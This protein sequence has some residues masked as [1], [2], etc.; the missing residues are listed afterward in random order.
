META[1]KIVT[2]RSRRRPLTLPSPRKGGGD[3]SNPVSPPPGGE[4]GVRGGV[5]PE[6]PRS[7]LESRGLAEPRLPSPAVGRDAISPH[8]A[9]EPEVD[10]NILRHEPFISEYHDQ[11]Y[12]YALPRG[13]RSIYACYEVDSAARAHLEKTQ[14]PGFF[15][16]HYLVLRAR[17]VDNNQSW[18][19]EDYLDDKTSYWLTV[20]PNAEY[21]LELGY[22]RKGTRS[23]H[24]VALSNRVRSQPETDTQAECQNERRSIQVQ[25]Y[26]REVPVSA[27]EWRWNMYQYW[28]N[29]RLDRPAEQGCWALVLHMHLPF[30][31]HIEE[32]VALEEQWLFEAM[33]SCY[34]QLL[35]VFWNLD[36]AKIDFRMT[37]SI[38]PP[39]ISMLTD[40]GLQARYRA[41]LKEALALAERELRQHRGQA[42]QATLESILGRLN[43]A[44]KVFESYGGNI[45]NGFR[46]FQNLEKLEIITCA[47]THPILP[48]YMHYPEIVRGHIQLA[49][50]QYQRVFGRWPRGMWLPEN[51]FVPGLDH[52]L[53]AEGIKWTLVN[54]TGLAR[55][56]TRAWYNTARPVI[57]HGNLAVFGIDEETRAQVWSREAGYPGD[58]R[59]KEWYRDLGYD[60]DWDY[61]PEYW[62]ACG[63]RRFTGL[64]YFR[65]TGKGKP[66]HEKQPYNPEWAWQALVE[67]AGQF[68]CHRGAQVNHLRRQYNLK[69]MVV[70][71][72][73]AE[74]F[75]HWWEEGPSW[76]EMVF[77]KMLYDQAI[78]RPVT[79]GEFLVEQREHQL[80]T[81]GMSTWG[82]KAT[83]ETWLDGRQFRPNCWIYR[84]L[85]R[86]GEKMIR[87]AS[88]RREAQGLERRALNQAAREL[89]LAQA[90]DWTF[91]ISMDA[92]ARYAETRLVK[93]IDRAKELLRQVEQR[94]VQTAY[95]KTLE[96]NDPLLADDMDFRV[97]CRP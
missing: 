13:P 70:S 96:S 72:Y 44:R 47:G 58:P 28:K 63:V 37:V 3:V 48:F 80:L 12:L 22:R 36:S 57:T 1:D 35:N 46:D 62:R 91:L 66:L 75:G 53:A 33:T 34:T 11:T 93:H 15:H 40:P 38:S 7:T 97:F 16:N 50:R 77:R 56:N 41:Y 85:F 6:Q 43:V 45:L 8:V 59:Y 65:I 24:R 86:I 95:L 49:C 27:N 39:L 87:L 61:L 73:D 5:P 92:S 79:P 9:P 51:A 88:E 82:N 94:C 23:F 31:K 78:V 26:S 18:D 69:P 19:I 71:A 4:G 25:S 14:G 10:F 90:S 60:A 17:R 76:I 89:M 21:E 55:G 54:A 84:H 52:F 68:V 83:F 64:K 29:C 2:E 32:P 81:P 42:F 67:Q 30:V 74:L 20:A